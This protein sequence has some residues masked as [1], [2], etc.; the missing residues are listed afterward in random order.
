[1]ATYRLGGCEHNS[2]RYGQRERQKW[3]RDLS[4]GAG[5][6]R[7]RIACYRHRRSTSDDLEHQTDKTVNG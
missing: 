3:R 6:V 1:M 7:F 2:K 4:H 5:M